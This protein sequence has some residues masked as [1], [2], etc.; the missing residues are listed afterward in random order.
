MNP[1]SKDFNVGRLL[2]DAAQ[3]VGKFPPKFN[4]LF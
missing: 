2:C 1:D 4:S 3:T